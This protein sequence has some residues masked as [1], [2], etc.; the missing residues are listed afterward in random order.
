MVKLIAN[1]DLD[2]YAAPSNERLRIGRRFAR[3]AEME[4]FFAAQNRSNRAIADAARK[5][6][7]ISCAQALP[8]DLGD[9]RPTI[10]FV[11]G[12]FSCGKDLHEV[13]VIDFVRSDE[14]ESDAFCRQGFGAILERLARGIPVQLS[15]PVTRIDYSGR[16]A[17]LE[18]AQGT[19]R[20][21][22]VIVT[23]SVGVLA[24]G[25]LEFRPH[26]PVRHLEAV[27]SLRLG[28]YDHIALDLPGNPL[29][30]R[31]DDLIYEKAVSDRTAALLANVSGTSL[32]LV[33]VGGSFGR[34]L[35]AQGAAAMVDFAV[36][37]LADL[38]GSGV[39]A[40]VKRSYATQWNKDPG[41]LG[42][43]SSAAPGNQPARRV[44]ME[45]IND[46][47]WFAGEAVDEAWWGTVG[48]AWE[49]GIRA[50]DAV[51]K[52]LGPS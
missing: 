24:A 52:R 50:A 46:R 25:S 32:C 15:T 23:V 1:T 16:L 42:A 13:S 6:T 11:L 36:G 31:S 45:S 19:L 14:R 43:F 37:W 28:S 33:D 2:V 27:A 5:K 18:T 8:K 40:A 41:V 38:F 9:L 17:T 39:K 21:Q 30:L 3:P 35:A 7:D 29:G 47:L 49:S 12:P 22:A 4:T 48:G 20:A 10:E 44:L 26:L 34:G 51:I